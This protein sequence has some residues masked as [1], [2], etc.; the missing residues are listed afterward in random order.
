MGVAIDSELKLDSPAISR[1]DPVNAANRL[2]HSYAEVAARIPEGLSERST[3]T[4][5]ARLPR[6][7][8]PAYDGPGGEVFSMPGKGPSGERMPG[9]TEVFRVRTI[10]PPTGILPPLDVNSAQD[11]T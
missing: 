4:K 10:G 1:N 2:E 5:L 6:A 9:A 11:C 3:E 8:P 7:S